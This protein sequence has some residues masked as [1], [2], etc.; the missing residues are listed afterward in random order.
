M[1]QTF[2]IALV[3][4]SPRA[5]RLSANSGEPSDL[6]PEALWAIGVSA[7]EYQVPEDLPEG[8]FVERGTTRRKP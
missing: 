5:L 1:K 8:E 4:I 6:D 3:L 2:Q 7:W